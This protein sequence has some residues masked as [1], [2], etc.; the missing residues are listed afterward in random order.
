MRFVDGKHIVTEGPF[1]ETDQLV[2][3][4]WMWKVKPWEEAIEWA[5]RCSNPMPGTE[6][7]IEIR[8]GFDAED[9]ARSSRLSRVSRRHVCARESRHRAMPH[10]HCCGT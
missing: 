5:K 6:A 1:A 7:E 10:R 9:L 4:F 2:A 8:Q 3:G